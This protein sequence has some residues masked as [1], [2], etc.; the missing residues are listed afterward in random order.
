VLFQ[1]LLPTCV[2]GPSGTTTEIS[3]FLLSFS[4]PPPSTLLLQVLKVL[5]CSIESG[6]HW[7][8]HHDQGLNGNLF[9][10]LAH[11]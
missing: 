9:K 5:D 2:Y 8:D 11:T 1:T 6:D 3:S 10:S 4:T 7:V